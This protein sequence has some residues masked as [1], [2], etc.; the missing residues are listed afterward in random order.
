MWNLSCSK[1]RFASP[2]YPNL[3]NGGADCLWTLTT[4]T[5]AQF[6]LIC[7]PLSVSCTGDYLLYSPSGDTTFKDSPNPICGYKSFINWLYLMTMI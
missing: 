6:T 2:N 7:D 4:S 1:G 3:Y 5:D